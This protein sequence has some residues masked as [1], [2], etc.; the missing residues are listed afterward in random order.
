MHIKSSQRLV[1]TKDF[2][3]A[4]GCQG[5]E[6]RGIL[7]ETSQP[8]LGGQPCSVAFANFCGADAN[9]KRLT[10]CHP[11]EL[12]KDGPNRL[13]VSRPSRTLYDGV[14]GTEMWGFLDIS[15]AYG[16][17]RREYFESGISENLGPV[18]GHKCQ[19][20]LPSH[21]ACCSKSIVPFSLE[22]MDL[23]VPL[24]DPCPALSFH[25]S[26]RCVLVLN[27]DHP[28]PGDTSRTASCGNGL[29]EAPL[30]HCPSPGPKPPSSLASQLDLHLV[31]DP[32]SMWQPELAS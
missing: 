13:S 9:F 6:H 5:L 14:F 28:T 15:V 11:G 22:R 27:Q 30:P 31:S 21:S 3:A 24:H 20:A 19:A 18:C 16:N 26:I 29:P 12:G 10:R 17:T 25:L 23:D 2:C 4:A 1:L 32:F 8:A 7:G